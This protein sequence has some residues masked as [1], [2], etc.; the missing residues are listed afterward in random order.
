MVPKTRAAIGNMGK[1]TAAAILALNKS[2]MRNIGSSEKLNVFKSTVL[3]IVNLNLFL[4]DYCEM[5]CI[6]NLL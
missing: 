2:N 3:G 4:I 6:Y 5:I 1:K